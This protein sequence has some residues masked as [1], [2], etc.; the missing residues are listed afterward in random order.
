MTALSIAATFAIA[1]ATC[2]D[3]DGEEEAGIRDDPEAVVRAFYR[4]RADCGREA[5]EQIYDLTTNPTGES[6]EEFVSRQ[7]R[8]ERRDGCRPE[9]PPKVSTFVVDRSEDT[10]TI[11][12]RLS[13]DP[14]GKRGGRI[15]LVRADEG[16]K[17]DTGSG[18]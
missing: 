15:R 8:D 5:A 14:E 10:A 16:W 13:G 11:D 12:V 17:L 18:Q 6:R 1:L 9:R 7:L 3:G 4:A 2:G